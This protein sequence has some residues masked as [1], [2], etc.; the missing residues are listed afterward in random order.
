MQ[1]VASIKEGY[2]YAR[3]AEFMQTDIM[4]FLRWMRV[5]GDILL[6]AGELLLVIFIIGL[7]FG[8][9]FER[10]NGNPSL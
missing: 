5:P 3:S 1:S 8:M 2:W 10:K 4:H 9:V 6:A 7:K